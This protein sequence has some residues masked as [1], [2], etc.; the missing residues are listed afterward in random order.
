MARAASKMPD[1]G[2]LGGSFCQTD[3]VLV[4]GGFLPARNWPACPCRLLCHCLG[5]APAPCVLSGVAPYFRPSCVSPPQ[6]RP[7]RTTP[8]S[9]PR[10][11]GASCGP[12]RGGHRCSAAP[13]A[14]SAATVALGV[15][16]AS[17]RAS[18]AIAATG[19]V[20]L[21]LVRARA[22]ATWPNVVDDSWAGW[23]REFDVQTG[24]PSPAESVSDSVPSPPMPS[25]SK[26]AIASAR[27]VRNFGRHAAAGV[28]SN[29]VLFAWWQG[30]AVGP[31]AAQ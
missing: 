6:P 24:E 12:R 22:C 4:A 31:V 20:T 7:G 25:G 8:P 15:A 17:D 19:P 13:P 21:L 9:R 1:G 29:F 2:D 10:P 23:Q 30:D 11:G 26:A 16:L 28:F 14:A 3:P 5:L 18:G 27:Q